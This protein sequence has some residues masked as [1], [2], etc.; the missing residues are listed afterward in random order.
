MPR[1]DL[2]FK[3]KTQLQP[4]I[5]K[6]SAKVCKGCFY[7]IDRVIGFL[8]HYGFTF[9]GQTAFPIPRKPRKSKIGGSKSLTNNKPSPLTL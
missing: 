9:I 7:E 8:E 2:C 5:P 6:C 3:D 4:P 1:C